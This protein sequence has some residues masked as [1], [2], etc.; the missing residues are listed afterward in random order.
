MLAKNSTRYRRENR[1]TKGDPVSCFLKICLVVI[2]LS[3]LIVTGKLLAAWI[4]LPKIDDQTEAAMHF[5][6]LLFVLAV[7]IP[8]V[9]GAEIGLALLM[10]LGKDAALEVYFAM[11][12]ALLLA[13]TAGR[14]V[15]VRFVAKL[16]N[17]AESRWRLFR[18]RSSCVHRK[19]SL[20]ITKRLFNFVAT[21]KHVSLGAIL[22]MPGNS[23]LG[24]GGGIALVA[25]ASRKYSY[26]G[27]GTTIAIAVLPLPLLFYILG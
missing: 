11:L 9:P 7:A 2:V 12:L 1:D 27:F 19:T 26:L 20:A 21:N 3:A 6:L 5:A 24:G 22:N 8:F 16:H 17:R 14:L 10:I 13:F 15:P 4:G 23:I 18:L 25:G